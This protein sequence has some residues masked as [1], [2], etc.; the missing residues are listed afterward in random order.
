MTQLTE[1]VGTLM[2]EFNDAITRANAQDSP[3]LRVAYMGNATTYANGILTLVDRFG[4]QD[5]K[6]RAFQ[7]LDEGYQSAFNSAV[8]RR[9]AQSK[10]HW[11]E[12]YQDLSDQIAENRAAIRTHRL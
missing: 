11:R 9:D 2:A 4:T 6:E 7:Q 10:P 5:E 12:V 3:H 1:S 8:E